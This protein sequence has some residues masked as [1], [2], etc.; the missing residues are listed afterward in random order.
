MARRRFITQQSKPPLFPC[1]Y[2]LD[3]DCPENLISPCICQGTMK[4]VHNHCLLRWYSLHPETG[5]ACSIC[6]TECAFENDS[7]IEKRLSSEFIK[8]A[9]LEHPFL[10]IFMYHWIYSFF[11][12]SVFQMEHLG[13]LRMYYARFQQGFT[14]MYLLIFSYAVWK[15]QQKR[16]YLQKWLFTSRALLIIFHLY[17]LWL[18]PKYLWI[19]GIA[20]NLCCFQ[21]F[22]T[23]IQILEEMNN[24]TTFRFVTRQPARLLSYS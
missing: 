10:I 1:R 23:H 22:Y 6:K 17:T 20:G 8:R 4:Y 21:Y 5:L 19:G 9:G 7:P 16:L 12:I 3:E 11:C 13:S 24:K 2:C 18:I 14:G 15:I